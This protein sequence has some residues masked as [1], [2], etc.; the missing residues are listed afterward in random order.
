MKHYIAL[1]GGTSNTRLRLIS[2]GKILSVEKLSIGAGTAGTRERWSGAIRDAALSLLEKNGLEMKDVRAV[3]GAGMITSEYGLCPLTHLPAPAGASELAAGMAKLEIPGLEIPCFFVPGVKQLG[4]S[5]E[6]SDMMR[7]EEAE[8]VGLLPYGGA[9]CVYVLPGTHAKH[10]FVDGE[11][12]ITS[13]KTFM[14]GELI[15]AISSS[16]ILRDAVDLSVEGFDAEALLAGYDAAVQNGISAALFKT[17]IMKNLFCAGKRACYSFFLGALLSD[18]IRSL[19]NS[20][21]R[22]VLVAGKPA[23]RLPTELLLEKRTEIKIA[24]CPE[25]AIENASAFG[26]IEIYKIMEKSR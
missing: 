23:L 17:R 6:A 5:A 2:D 15:G 9:D 25:A 4:E 12:R 3:I 20:G 22:R 1:D 18:E 19:E 10:V 14:T 24:A 11:G 26:V 8:T 7:G 21:A 13:F 16:T